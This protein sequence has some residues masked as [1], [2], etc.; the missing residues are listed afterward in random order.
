MAELLSM[1]N[2]CLKSEFLHLV[3]LGREPKGRVIVNDISGP[4]EPLAV[5]FASTGSL[6]L[7][8]ADLGEAADL[9][10]LRSPID[11][12]VSS[13]DILGTTRIREAVLV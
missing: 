13:E 12:G 4:T 3:F 5:P 11:V 1:I 6:E 2:C 9:V 7:V 10:Q 8:R